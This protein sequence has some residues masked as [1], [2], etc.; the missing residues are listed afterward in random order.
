MKKFFTL[1]LSSCSILAANA[2]IDGDGYYRGYNRST[3]RYIYVIDN[4][5]KANIEANQYDTQAVKLLKDH[6]LTLDDPASVLYGTNISGDQWDLQ[7]QGTGIKG[8]TGL[9]I[10]VEGSN[11]NYKFSGTYDGQTVY[12]TD[13]TTSTTRAEGKLATSGNYKYWGASPLNQTDNYLGV[14]GKFE[15]NGKYYTP[16]Y[17]SFPFDFYSTGMKAWYVSKV[18]YDHN[19]V[20]IKE[21][22]GVVQKSTP[23]IIEMSSKECV[24]NK[25]DLKDYTSNNNAPSDNLLSGVYFSYA[26]HRVEMSDGSWHVSYTE[27]DSATMRVLSVKDNKLVYVNAG[28]DTELLDYVQNA[29][30]VDNKTYAKYML[31][32]NQSYLTVP[33][34]T[35]DEL[36]V[37]TEEEYAAAYPSYIPGDANGDGKVLAIDLTLLTNVILGKTSE[38]TINK[39]AVDFDNNNK[40]EAIDLTKLTNLILGK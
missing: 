28:T 15:A 5:G 13:A 16:Y 25:L 14:T 1:L 22:E 10:K 39:Q 30:D 35:A 21:V 34:G 36:T 23:V 6:D 29:I 26:A 20:V 32:A 37:M 2:Q 4:A 31:K 40:L 17:V 8:I 19:V 9:T 11:P 27:Y 38:S 33:A 3:E 12:L 7:A 24:N 18:D